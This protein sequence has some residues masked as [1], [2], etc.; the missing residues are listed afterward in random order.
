MDQTTIVCPHCGQP[1]E[2]S[3][4]IRHQLDAALQQAKGEQQARLR[5]E[6][7]RRGAEQTQAAVREAL[8]EARMRNQLELEKLRRANEQSQLQTRQLQ[9]DQKQLMDELLK[10]Q[11]ERDDA[12]RAAQKQLLEQAQKLREEAAQKAAE[13]FSVR[14]REQ[15]HTIQTLREQLTNAKLVAEQ[16]SQ[17]LQGE[18]LELDMEQALRATFPG[19]GITEVR[20]G[21]RGADIRQVVNERAYTDCGLIL[22]ECKNA[23]TYQAAWLPKLRE[24]L[25]DEKARF[26]V[27]VFQPTAGG[28][29]DFKQLDENIY[30]VKPRFAVMVAGFLREV[31]IRVAIAARNAQGKDVKL[32]M[33]YDYLT[34]TEFSARIRAIVESYDEL[35]RQ[36]EQEKK[37]AQKRWAAQEKILRRATASLYGMSGDLQGIAGREIIA[38]PGEEDDPLSLPPEEI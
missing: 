7:E 9:Q 27:I 17:Q 10:A 14:L 19:D 36:L 8:E 30:L 34:G 22:W 6:Y 23:K 31:C 20:K 32:E 4:A 2:I 29:D 37:Q 33:M 13:D 28:G 16:G 15:E 26:G 3:E 35:S 1:F 38:L 12:A 11:R 21:E 25:M 24:E 5:Q 18:I